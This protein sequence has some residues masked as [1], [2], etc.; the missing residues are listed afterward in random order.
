ME[1]L[2]SDIGY[3]KKTSGDHQ[4]ESRLNPTIKTFLTQAFMLFLPMDDALPHYYLE[5]QDQTKKDAIFSVYERNGIVSWYFFKIHSYAFVMVKKIEVKVTT[6]IAHKGKRVALWH[7]RLEL[8][9]KLSE[10]AE[11]FWNDLTKT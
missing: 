6:W 3:V 11:N 8:Q 10:S 7:Y 2:S 1:K 4:G 5:L 9:A